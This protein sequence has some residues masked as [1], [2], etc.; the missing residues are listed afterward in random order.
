MFAVIAASS[1]V[2]YSDD[3]DRDC[4]HLGRT[5]RSGDIFP[6]GD[7]CNSCSCTDGEVACT[8]IGCDPGDAGV[9]DGAPAAACAPTLGCP[10]GPACNGLCCG[11]GERCNNGTCACGPNAACGANDGC[12]AAGPISQD[13]CGSICCGASGPCPQ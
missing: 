2:L 9:G 4:T 6:A 12:E 5:Y 1:C 8:L 3:R 13:Q 7:G 10:A 11:A